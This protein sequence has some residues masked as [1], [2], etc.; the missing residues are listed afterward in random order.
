MRELNS[1]LAFAEQSK[2]L[3][4]AFKDYKD[5]WLSANRHVKGKAFS[6]KSLDDK[7]KVITK[8]FTE[9]IEK[10]SG[11]SLKDADVA[12]YANNPMV[13]YFA[14]E[15]IDTMVDMIIPDV[16]NTSVGLIADIQY[17][18][19][20]DTGK[21][22]MRNNGLFNVSKA[23]YRNRDTLMQR[24]DDS[25][26]T[27]VPEN[28]QVTTYVS[29]YEILTGRKT[30]G[31]Y[32]MKVGVSIETEMLNEVWSAFNTAMSSA[33]LPVALSVTNYTEKSA[34]SLAQKVQAYNRATPIFVGTAVALKD[35]LPSNTNYR[36]FLD[37]DYF[38]LG[39]VPVF[40]GYDVMTIGQIADKDNLATYGL[41][42]DDTRIYVVSPA[43]DKVVKVVVGKSLSHVEDG[44]FNA[45]LA[46][47]NTISK[48]WACGVITNSIAG[49]IVL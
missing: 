19:W 40:N 35:L 17:L 26:A 34:I 37:D 1:V 8:L 41:A 21:F 6:D 15:I 48:A 36:Y 31:E 9:E 25:T 44:V 22:D 3:Y 24:L 33:T 5:H 2:D 29:L 32:V 43:S 27:L 4:T 47:V 30:L 38:R 39:S 16:L 45:N 23:G 14:D 49:V 46:Q 28:H 18:D 20:G 13:R 7:D 12:H 11:L 10:R 42:I